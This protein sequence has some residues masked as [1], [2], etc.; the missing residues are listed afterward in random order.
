MDVKKI[1]NGRSRFLEILRFGMVGFLAT[2][3]QY[4][5][6]LV[7]VH[8]VKVPAVPSALISYAIS[9]VFNFFMS[10]YFTFHSSPN[11][12]KGI[13]FTLSHLF[14]MGLQTGLVAIF[15]GLVGP[16]LALLP[17]IAICFPIN[18]LLVRF[19]FTARV[20]NNKSDGGKSSEKEKTPEGVS[21]VK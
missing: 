1:I 4:G 15:K 16:S 20:F 14:N 21:E 5:L 17:A 13:G 2:L 11:A 12:K 9:F 6:Y 3:L 19:A 10:S 18:Y 7:F 8:F